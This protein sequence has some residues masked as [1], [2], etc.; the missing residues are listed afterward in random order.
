[1]G[2]LVVKDPPHIPRA[3]DLGFDPLFNTIDSLVSYP[4]GGWVGELKVKSLAE[5]RK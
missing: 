2:S 1:M 5:N 3:S 4:Q